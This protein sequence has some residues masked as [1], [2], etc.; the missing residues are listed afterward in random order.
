MDGIEA[1]FGF[2]RVSMATTAGKAPSAATRN[3]VESD[4]AAAIDC[5]AS[6]SPTLGGVATV[7]VTG[8]FDAALIDAVL[9][10]AM[11]P[12]FHAPRETHAVSSVTQNQRVR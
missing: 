1:C 4:C 12:I 9:A 10:D 8:V 11:E 7:N 6:N 2:E 5:D 3:A